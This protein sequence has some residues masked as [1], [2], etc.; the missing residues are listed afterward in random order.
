MKGIKV[1]MEV[2]RGIRNSIILSILSYASET[3]TWIAEQQTRI[4]TVDMSYIRG[5]CGVSRWDKESNENMYERFCM[6]VTAKGVDCSGGVGEA[7]CAEMV[8]THGRHRGK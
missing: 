5:A 2:K 3:W 8:W 6:G 1:S 4:R 7:W